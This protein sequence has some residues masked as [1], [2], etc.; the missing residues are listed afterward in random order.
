M[1]QMYKVFIQ[2]RPLNFISA[3][4]ISKYRGFFIHNVTGEKHKQYV[5][6]ILRTMPSDIQMFIISKNPLEALRNFF[7]EYE[8]IEAAGGI[9]KRKDKFLFIKRNGLWDLPKGKLEEG[10][11]PEIAAIREV[12][13][14][15]GIFNLKLGRLIYITLHTYNYEGV[16]TLKK[17]YWY[18]MNYKGPKQGIPQEDEGI[19]KIAWVD[20]D[21]I[22]KKY[23]KTYA[24]LRNLLNLYFDYD[25]TKTTEIASKLIEQ[26]ENTRN[27]S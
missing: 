26:K 9:V 22:P 3:D 21:A 7:K 12:E 14:E 6:N 23:Q 18:E 25:F 13:E 5:L 20:F 24:S 15:C 8:F 11:K 16:P 4:E 10:E 2:E 27:Y 1:V 19:T 17:T